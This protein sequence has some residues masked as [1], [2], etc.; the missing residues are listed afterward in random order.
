MHVHGKAGR[1]PLLKEG[2]PRR[3]KI[4]MLPQDFGAA[5]VVNIS[6]IIDNIAIHTVLFCGTSCQEV[7]VVEGFSIRP[8]Q[9]T[10]MKNSANGLTTPAAPVT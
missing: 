10:W 8:L 6:Q 9:P 7:A 3:S 4:V 5:G 1:N 2:S